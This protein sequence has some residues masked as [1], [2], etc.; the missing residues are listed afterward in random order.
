MASRLESSNRR[1]GRLNGPGTFAL[2]GSDP[3]A[4]PIL[5]GAI[6]FAPSPGH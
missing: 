4:P 2:T 5:A 1:P 6:F 3:A